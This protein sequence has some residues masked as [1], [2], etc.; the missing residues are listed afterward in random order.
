MEESYT[1]GEINKCRLQTS[2]DVRADT[3]GKSNSTV[4]LS[5][6]YSDGCITVT[7]Q[8][9]NIN[10][11]Q[12]WLQKSC[13]KGVASYTKTPAGPL[14]AS[15]QPLQGLGNIHLNQKLDTSLIKLCTGWKAVALEHL[16]R[17]ALLSYILHILVAESLCSTIR[18]FAIIFKVLSHFPFPFQFL[19]WRIV[20]QVD[21]SSMK[22][23]F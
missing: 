6:P 11:Y 22:L 1:T 23:L 13:T 15:F 4:L 20:Y 7:L 5:G 16:K 17:S 12:N 3:V 9:Q 21:K 14:Q 8:S 19:F 2:K 18:A 10:C